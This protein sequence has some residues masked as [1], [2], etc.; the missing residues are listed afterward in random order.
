MI[1]LTYTCGS[2][3]FKDIGHLKVAFYRCN[4]G[5]PFVTSVHLLHPVLQTYRNI[6]IY[7]RIGMTVDFPIRFDI[8]HQIL[9][10]NIT[11]HSQIQTSQSTEVT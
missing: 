4:R 10:K 11:L 6:H 8:L 3:L 7:D 5:T 1:L 2:L 9:K